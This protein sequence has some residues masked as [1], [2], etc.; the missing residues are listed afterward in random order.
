MPIRGWLLLL[1]GLLTVWSPAALAIVAASQLA[2]RASPTAELVLLAIRLIVT[3]VGVAAGMAL[4]H[5]RPGAVRLAKTSLA[6]SG[7]EAVAR[8]S[9]RYGLSES[10]PGTRLPLA[11]SLIVFNAAWYLY[12]EKSR[13]VRAT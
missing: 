7:V 10:P 9:T 3:G 1:C 8:L 11:I 13:R 4:W 5:K 6:L 2:N 12:L